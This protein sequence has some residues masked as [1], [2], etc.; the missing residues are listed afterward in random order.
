MR[1]N[2]YF[3]VPEAP[4]FN[5]AKDEADVELDFGTKD[6]EPEQPDVEVQQ[7]KE[8][9]F[10]QIFNKPITPPSEPEL[11]VAMVDPDIPMDQQVPEPVKPKSYGASLFGVEDE[12]VIATAA[13]DFE[14][15]AVTSSG[16]ESDE[17]AAVERPTMSTGEAIFADLPAMPNIGSTGATLFG[18][19]EES[20]KVKHPDPAD[21]PTI[22]VL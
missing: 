9:G 20:G 13:A 18:M 19:S 5:E 15:E 11:A 1:K 21:H 17:P 8:E 16:D 4:P 6:P 7:P 10:G 12:P 22:L 2:I 3:Q 14:P